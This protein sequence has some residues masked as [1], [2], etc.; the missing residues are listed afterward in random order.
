ME[1]KGK[2]V[3]ANE[4]EMADTE[5]ESAISPY[6]YLKALEPGPQLV[7]ASAISTVTV[8]QGDCMSRTPCRSEQN[9]CQASQE[10][11]EQ[12]SKDRSRQGVMRNRVACNV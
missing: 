3:A 7:S 11:M 2:T 1:A 8:E 4:G 10:A 9:G 12:Y 5:L 6:L